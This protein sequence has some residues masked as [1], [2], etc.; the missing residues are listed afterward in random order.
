MTRKG[1]LIMYNSILIDEF[2]QKVKN[3]TMN[4]VDVREKDEWESGHLKDA[5]HVPLSDLGNQKEK[6]NKSQDY[7]IICHSGRRSAIAS[8]RLS[9]EGYKVTNVLGGMSAWKGETVK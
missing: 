5:L 1:D 4:V 8:E 2:E 6:L 3:E 9:E 7:F